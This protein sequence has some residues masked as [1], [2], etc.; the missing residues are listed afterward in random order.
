LL[1][2]ESGHLALLHLR[3]YD[4]KKHMT[5]GASPNRHDIRSLKANQSQKK[6]D[7]R[8]EIAKKS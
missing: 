3:L 8:K 6:R 7:K 2:A 1:I 5:A 4:V